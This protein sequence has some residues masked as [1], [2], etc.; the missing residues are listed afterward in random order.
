MTSKIVLTAFIFMVSVSCTGKTRE[1]KSVRLYTLD[2]GSIEV[3]DMSSFSGEAKLD[4]EKAE[5][6]NPCFLIRHKTGYLIWD[7]GHP[8]K[9]ADLPDGLKGGAFHSKMKTKLTDHLTELEL[10]PDDID[11][12]S[13][14]HLHP[15][16]AGNAN[17][18]AGSTW[19]ANKTE[20][21][22]MFSD[23]MRKNKEF[24]DNF[25]ALETAKTVLFRDEHDV[26]GDSSVVIKSMPG[27]T[28]GSSVLLVRLKNSGAMLLT[29]DLYTHERA[30]EL[31][32]IPAFNT[33]KKATLESRKKFET[34]AKKENARVVIQHSKVDFDALPTFPAFLD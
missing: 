8:Q 22:Y 6:A 4:G 18:F 25:S 28:P 21:S 24:F 13:I 26:F 20:H 1:D 23:A 30:R 11:F 33:D 31:N 2:C 34:L 27:H 29:G 10:K 3:A 16:H 14:S 32:T 19:I 7:T 5:L 15:D 9:L 17:I 12:L